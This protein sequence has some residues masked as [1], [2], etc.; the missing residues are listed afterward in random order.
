MF[1]RQEVDEGQA[2]HDLVIMGMK[3]AKASDGPG[4][5]IISAVNVVA[6]LRVCA[7][8]GMVCYPPTPPPPPPQLEEGMITQAR[9][10]RSPVTKGWRRVTVEAR[11]EA[12]VVAVVVVVANGPTEV[13]EAATTAAAAAAAVPVLVP[14][15]A[16]VAEAAAAAAAAAEAV[17]EVV[18]VAVATATI[19]GAAP[20][21]G[22][23]IP[24]P[25][26]RHHVHRHAHLSRRQGQRNVAQGCLSERMRRTTCGDDKR[27]S[28]KTPPTS[29]GDRTR[30]N[31]SVRVRVGTLIVCACGFGGES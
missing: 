28:P 27:T 6:R 16:A 10:A 2:I 4:T 26:V 24:R 15:V 17:A 29:S 13:P 19:A 5:M 11:R 1:S 12:V 20:S 22:R 9:M 30:K 25:H 18:A 23:V 14:A 31:D 3:P 8:S 21:T 7:C